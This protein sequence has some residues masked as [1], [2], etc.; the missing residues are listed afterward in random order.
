VVTPQEHA[1]T[2]REAL[3]EDYLGPDP[4]DPM[5]GEKWGPNPAALAALDA[6]LAQAETAERLR[7]DYDDLKLRRNASKERAEAAEA[8]RDAAVRERDQIGAALGEP[9]AECGHI[10]WRSD[11]YVDR[12]LAAEGERDQARDA[13]ARADAECGRQH[14]RA[15]NAEAAAEQAR[16]ALDVLARWP[17]GDIEMCQSA[18]AALSEEA[19]THEDR[20]VLGEGGC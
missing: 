13:L 3:A 11:G 10:D 16:N 14:V 1:N 18:R 20:M 5:A 2:I 8:E 12:F 6:L 9:C 17:H 4:Q 7:V 15:V 19:W